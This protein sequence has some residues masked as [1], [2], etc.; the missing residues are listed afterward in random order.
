MVDPYTP[1]TIARS[2]LLLATTLTAE[3][4]LAGSSTVRT[5]A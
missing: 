2:T 4:T 3:T 5:I 1:T